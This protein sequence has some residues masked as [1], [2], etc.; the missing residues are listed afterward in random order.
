M[1][2]D[3]R[4]SSWKGKLLEILSYEL[5]ITEKL[6]PNIREER[7]ER[8]RVEKRRR[9]EERRGE[10]RGEEIVGQRIK[11]EERRGEKRR[12][13]RWEERVKIG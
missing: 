13:V 4:L 1:G 11:G 9:R 5:D 10:K 3:W 6:L 12:E 2:L 8:E 7:G